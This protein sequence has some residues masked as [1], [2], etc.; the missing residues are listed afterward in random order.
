MLLQAALNG[1]YGKDVHFSMPLSMDELVRDAIAC[2]SAGAGAI[3]LHPRDD[4]GRETL[5]PKVVNRVA[6]AVREA[7]GVPVGVTTGAWIEPDPRRRVELVG[8][9]RSPDYT[10]VNLSEPGAIEVMEALLEV[11]VG[12]EA[13]VWAV[14]D[15]GRLV[16]AGLGDRMTRILVEPIASLAGEAVRLVKD[17]HVALDKAGITTPRLQHGDGDSTW[18]LLTDAVR[19]GIDTRVGLED[20]VFAPNGERT[21]GNAALIQAARV[22]G[23]GAP[24]PARS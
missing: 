11:G 6:A 19:R 3:H 22:L 21:S 23:A 20:T 10:S 2:V 12:I 16:T 9:W 13:G 7:C 1:P 18:P 17:I 4:D 15:A 24:D 14:E 5:D 8:E